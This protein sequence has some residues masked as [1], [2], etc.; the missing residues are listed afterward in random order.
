MTKKT[1]RMWGLA[2][3]LTLLVVVCVSSIAIGSRVIP[4]GEV[5]D[6]LW[7]DNVQGAPDAVGIVQDLRLPR[8]VLG[9][10]VGLSIGA[11]GALT[12]GAHPQP[13]V[14]PGISASTPARRCAVVTGVT[15]LGITRR[16]STWASA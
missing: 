15:V 4:I 2:L 3:L 8:T 7:A 9:L 16:S 11:A 6:A 14:G 13:A 1:R 5:W 12:Q 10:I